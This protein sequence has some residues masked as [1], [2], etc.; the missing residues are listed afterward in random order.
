[1]HASQRGFP[2]SMALPPSFS[3]HQTKAP[4]DSYGGP[5]L[6][7]T[8][9]THRHERE[10]F[11]AKSMTFDYHEC[12]TFCGTHR[13][14]MQDGSGGTATFNKPQ[15]LVVLEDGSVVCT[16]VQNNSIRVISPRGDDV[17]TVSWSN[18]KGVAKRDRAQTGAQSSTLLHP[19]GLAVVHDGLLICDQGHNRL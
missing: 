15:G 4:R 14:G 12:F 11:E 6:Y 8:M 13:S 19:R 10:S 3:T 7:D 2:Q 17:R 9:V 1:M 16:D 18:A 5:D